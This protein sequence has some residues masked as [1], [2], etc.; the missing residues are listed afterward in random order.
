[1]THIKIPVNFPYWDEP[2]IFSKQEAFIDLL[3]MANK[4][5]GII[6]TSIRKLS[7]Q[8]RW[9]NTK[10]IKFLNE[11][12]SKTTI[13][14]QQSD[15]KKTVIS[16]ID[17]ELYRIVNDNKTTEK[18]QKKDNENTLFSYNKYE[19]IFD[20]WNQQNIT[21][22]RKLTK[23][24][25]QEID[26][27]LKK[28]SEEEIIEAITRYSQVYH[29]KDYYFQYAW[30]LPNFL[31]QRNALPDFLEDG[32]K[33]INYKERNKPAVTPITENLFKGKVPDFL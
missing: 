17:W 1:M 28:Y 32:Q 7:Q 9:S 24:I 21:V 11:L 12:E 22:H 30:T 3:F 2:R 23:S 20:Y 15:R 33:W 13:K 19:K 18:R 14:R 26:K 8:W 10:V 6:E 5:D 27:A 16:V 31:K 25:E 29:D 4:T